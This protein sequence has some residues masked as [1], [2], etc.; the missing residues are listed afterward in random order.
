MKKLP[1]PPK[2]TLNRHRCQT[3]AKNKHLKND[4]DNDKV[5][6]TSNNDKICNIFPLCINE[7]IFKNSK[8]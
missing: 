1:P 4:D 7:N 5:H 2:A 3:Y 8:Y 6:D